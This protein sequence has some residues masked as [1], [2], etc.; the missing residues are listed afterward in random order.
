MNLSI[1]FQEAIFAHILRL[2]VENILNTQISQDDI[3]DIDFT[4]IDTFIYPIQIFK[5]WLLR[6]SQELGI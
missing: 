3:R 6:Y 1:Q 4:S 5:S 2:Y